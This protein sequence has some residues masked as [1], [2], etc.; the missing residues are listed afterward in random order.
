MSS[1]SPSH[2]THGPLMHPSR[3]PAS[4]ELR[5]RATSSGTASPARRR[6]HDVVRRQVPELRRQERAHR[7]GWPPRPR[8]PPLRAPAPS[9]NPDIS[10]TSGGRVREREPRHPGRAPGRQSASVGTLR[11][12][13]RR[14]ARALSVTSSSPRSSTSASHARSAGTVGRDQLPRHQAHLGGEH[15]LLV[16]PLAS[17]VVKRTDRPLFEQQR[18]VDQA[19]MDVQQE[20]R[21]ERVVVQ[22]SQSGRFRR[23]ARAAR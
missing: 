12:R 2:R 5:A 23:C 13:A 18:G 14:R 9:G 4:A 16:E 22:A 15:L 8:P 7:A 17:R 1:S 10:R 3:I 6:R 11:G 20:V 19:R 21:V